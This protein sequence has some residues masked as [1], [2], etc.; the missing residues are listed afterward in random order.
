MGLIP[1]FKKRD[2]QPILHLQLLV[3]FN[4]WGA[5]QLR[6]FVHKK[7]R[8]GEKGSKGLLAPDPE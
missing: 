6:A 7:Q 3:V 1:L 8:E 2:K 5:V 4:D